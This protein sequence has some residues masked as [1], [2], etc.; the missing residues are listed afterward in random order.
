M[1][2]LDELEQDMSRLLSSD[3]RLLHDLSTT[4]KIADL[5][6]HFDETTER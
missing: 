4:K 6:K 2:K 5:T 1:T 3:V